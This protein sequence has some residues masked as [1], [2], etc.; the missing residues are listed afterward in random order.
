MAVRSRVRLLLFQAVVSVVLSSVADQDNSTSAPAH[1]NGTSAAQ[2]PALGRA[3][4][5]SEEVLKQR[6]WRYLFPRS[7]VRS[8]PT[9]RRVSDTHLDVCRVLARAAQG[10]DMLNSV[11]ATMLQRQKK[12]EG[13]IAYVYECLGDKGMSTNLTQSYSSYPVVRLLLHN[14]FFWPWMCRYWKDRQEAWGPLSAPLPETLTHFVAYY[15]QAA[16]KKTKDD[17]S[18][19]DAYMIFS[20]MHRALGNLPGVDTIAEVEVADRSLPELELDQLKLSATDAAA[21]AQLF[22]YMPRLRKLRL[23]YSMASA[24]ASGKVI[25]RLDE[26]GSLQELYLNGNVIG[27]AGIGKLMDKL[28]SLKDLKKLHLKSTSLTPLGGATIAEKVGALTGLKDMALSNNELAESLSSMG[29][30]FARM[31]NL[32]IVII[33]PATCSE[34]ALPTVE[35]Q[36]RE[37]MHKHKS[38]VTPVKSKGKSFEMYDGGKS[39]ESQVTKWEA[40]KELLSSDRNRTGVWITIKKIILWVWIKTV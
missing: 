30:A 39:K 7:D 26:L 24:E 15:L 10:K 21:L 40:V 2:C 25:D 37:M 4:Y 18:G 28:S 36:M 12:E 33:S 5:C 17:R 23:T 29:E 13:W 19:E 31:P 27:D 6:D 16:S 34:A 20:S 32:E 38:R 11:K 3:R 9:R 14:D 35:R 8:L 1:G 22:P